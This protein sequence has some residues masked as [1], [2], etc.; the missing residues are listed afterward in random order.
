MAIRKWSGA[1]DDWTTAADWD[2][3]VPGTDDDAVFDT[4]LGYQVTISTDVKIASLTFES[5]ATLKENSGASLTLTGALVLRNGTLQLDGTTTLHGTTSL[6][7]ATVE[8]QAGT[9][10]IAGGGTS[11][12]SAFTVAQGAELLINSSYSFD[13]G[14]SISG[15][16]TIRVVGGGLTTDTPTYD[17]IVVVVE[18]NRS[19]ADIIGN[20]EA[21]YINKLASGGALL[22]NYHAVTHPSEPNYFALYAGNT[23][24]IQDDGNYT[25]PGPTLGSI[26]QANGKSFLGYVEADGVQKH[27]PWESFPEAFTVERDFGSFPTHPSDD[28]SQLP[29]VSFVIPNLNDDMHDGSVAQAD[30]WLAANLDSYAKWAPSNNSLFVVVWDEDD[31]SSGNQ[32]P[33]ILYGAHVN[34]G[35]YGASYNH[36]D[37]LKTLLSASHLSAPNQAANAPGIGDGIFT[38]PS[39]SLSGALVLTNGRVQLDGMTTVGSLSVSGGTLTGAGM[40]TDTG[41]FTWS[42]GEIDGTVTPNPVLSV[43]GTFTLTNGTHVFNHRTL[44]LNGTTNLSDLNSIILENGAVITN[45]GT[46]LASNDHGDFFNQGFFGIGTFDNFGRVQKNTTGNTGDTRFTVVFNNTDATV[47]V[48]S[49][50]LEIAGGGASTNSGVTIA[51]DAT[52]LITS[53]YSFDPASASAISGAGTVKLDS[54]STLIM[55]GS[56][57]ITGATII[58]VNTTATFNGSV[59]SVGALTLNH[60]TLTGTQD[61]TADAFVW[62]A[63]TLT[64]TSAAN[65]VLTVDEPIDL[66]GSNVDGATHLL[67]HRTL[68]LTGETH[69]GG[70][71]NLLILS[72][73]AVIGRSSPATMVATSSTT[74]AF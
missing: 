46:L 38:G 15:A 50:T 12:N 68:I 59:L 19:Y 4:G 74:R 72:S 61:I 34:T 73:G 71:N 60:G 29:D 64:S 16:G 67:D 35:T 63:G 3:G 66:N 62:T 25:E 8:V 65:A 36:Y 7:N 41:D 13:H 42:G 23:F 54:G 26:L 69:L 24:N 57:D 31:F 27:N 11:V 9:L 30:Q 37:L 28:F 14:S 32:V 1:T 55:S 10:E 22:A 43:D 40:V 33:A 51:A 20:S 49:G 6:T 58:G 47:D 44:G 48:Q 56:Y 2:T 5:D 21:P 53:N 52:L 17:H 45:H 39:L 18:E 70:K